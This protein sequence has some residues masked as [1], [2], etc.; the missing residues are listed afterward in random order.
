[1]ATLWAISDLHVAHRGN[2]SII[3]RI[4][5]EDDGDWLI[6][7]GDVSERTDDISDTLRRLKARFETVIW[8]PGNH[9]LYTTAKDPMQIFGVARYDY[10]V[11]MCRDLGVV[12]PEDI[13]PLFDPRNGTAPVRVVPMFLLY[14]YTFRPKG[15][16]NKLQALAV[17]RENNVVATDEFLLSSEPFQTRDAWSRAR[18][19]QTRRR[20]DRLDPAE[21]TVL[22]NHWP[23][24][25]EPTDALMY[26]EF[27]LWCGSE[28]TDDW[29]LRYNAMCSV[30]GHLHIPR[31]T[32]Y[33]GVR[34]E[35]VSVGYPR[36]WG[37]RGL[38]DPLLRK[39]VPDDGLLPEHLPEHGARFE[40][41][42]DYKERAEEFAQKL[43]KKREDVKVRR[44]EREQKRDETP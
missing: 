38:P 6:V 4:R 14:D 34:F 28:L 10:L 22:I 12:T 44:A 17:A 2:E 40:L 23:L 24:R 30:Y 41:P 7:A 16:V 21:R 11:Q 33:D 36:E 29:H 19:D 9:E 3:D 1:M 13:Y 35:E 42:P 15:T 18:I 37:R 5:P 8:T 27:A 20:L 25:R 31:T 43:A 39:I 26:P 32:W